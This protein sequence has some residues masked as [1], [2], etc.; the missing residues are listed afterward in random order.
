MTK[1]RLQEIATSQGFTMSQVQ[2]R[3]GLTM[4]MVRRYWYNQTRTISLDALDA[5][6]TLLNVS[7]GDL[8]VKETHS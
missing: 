3:T 4:T 2:R 6:S 8:L 1:L 5:L 7:P